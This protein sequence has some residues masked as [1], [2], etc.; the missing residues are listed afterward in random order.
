MRHFAVAPG[1]TQRQVQ[2]QKGDVRFPT[3]HYVANP[4]EDKTVWQVTK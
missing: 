2:T 3:S 4:R 1:V